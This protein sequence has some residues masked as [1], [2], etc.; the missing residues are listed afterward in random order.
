[1]SFNAAA[2][3]RLR[4]LDVSL[5]KL[6]QEVGRELLPFAPLLMLLGAL[7]REFAEDFVQFGHGSASISSLPGLTRQSM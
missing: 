6:G 2:F 3:Q 4:W 1:V 7:L 5:E